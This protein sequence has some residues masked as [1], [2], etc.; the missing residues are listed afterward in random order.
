ML[1]GIRSGTQGWVTP[2]YR[3]NI[4]ISVVSHEN[5]HHGHGHPDQGGERLGLRVS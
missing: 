4:P 2:K 1:P 5:R 3:K